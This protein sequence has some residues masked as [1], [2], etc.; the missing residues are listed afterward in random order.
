MKNPNAAKLFEELKK[1]DTPSITNVVATYPDDTE[2]CLGL[3]N[4]WESNWYTDQSLRCMY[5]ELGRRA[6]YAV[7]CVYGMP[8]PSF[9]RLSFGDVLKA[10][11]DSPKPVILIIKQDM[12][13]DIRNKNGL[14]GGNMTT[15][16]KTLGCV[17]VIS[18]GPSRDIDEIR[19]MDFQYML[20]GVTP[21]HGT[22]GVYAVNVPV[23]VCGMDVS[24]GEVI[25]MDENGAVKF[26]ADKLESVV[27]LAEKLAAKEAKRMADIARC[28]T[29]KQI[30][31]VMAGF[32][33]DDE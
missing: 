6:G 30:A 31:R 18:D 22:F 23:S 33:A 9:K 5:P 8:D 32:E 26:P 16:L 20:T 2:L 29:A 24:P 19:G 15:A 13:D 10:V 7:T 12:P 27:G 4:P 3:Y 25:H 1:Y 21:G 28:K 14:S 17:G 11:E